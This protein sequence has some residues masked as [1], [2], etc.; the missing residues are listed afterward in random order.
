M[1]GG[2]EVK[3]PTAISLR[4][5]SFKGIHNSRTERSKKPLFVTFKLATACDRM[6]EGEDY[7]CCWSSFAQGILR[8]KKS[9][10]D[11]NAGQIQD[12]NG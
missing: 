12:P 10:L 11:Q 4:R 1:Q 7:W 8:A 5:S 3:V 2:S 9:D 6:L